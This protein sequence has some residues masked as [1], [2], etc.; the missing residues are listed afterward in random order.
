MQEFGNLGEREQV[1]IAEAIHNLIKARRQ[2]IRSRG[3]LRSDRS[4]IRHQTKTA[5]SIVVLN[6]YCVNTFLQSRG[7]CA[8]II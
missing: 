7:T 4:P 8:T 1:K 2:D 5:P 3:K 6:R